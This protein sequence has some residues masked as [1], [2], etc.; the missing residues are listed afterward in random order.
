MP[1]IPTSL[2]GLDTPLAPQALLDIHARVPAALRRPV[3]GI[4]CGSGLGGLG[5]VLQDRVDVAY[6][7]IDGFGESTGES[8]LFLDEDG[9]RERRPA[10]S[11]GRSGRDGRRKYGN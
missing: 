4:V 6:H 7:E 8:S 10:G 11:A 2:P 1:I 5:D 9:R 3:V